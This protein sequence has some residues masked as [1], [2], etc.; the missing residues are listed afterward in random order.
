VVACF[1]EESAALQL[2]ALSATGGRMDPVRGFTPE[3]NARLAEQLDAGGP[4]NRAWDYY[5]ALV[6]GRIPPPAL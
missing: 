3:E 4:M 6:E 5:T 1:L 2:R